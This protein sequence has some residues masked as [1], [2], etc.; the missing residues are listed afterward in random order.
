MTPQV[1][2][3][4]L[5][6]QVPEQS[7][8]GEEIL[9]TD[10]ISAVVPAESEDGTKGMNIEEKAVTNDTDLLPDYPFYFNH[11][12][13]L[14]LNENCKLPYPN[15]EREYRSLDAETFSLLHK[16]YKDIFNSSTQLMASCKSDINRYIKFKRTPYTEDNLRETEKL[17]LANIRQLRDKFHSPFDCNICLFAIAVLR[18]LARTICQCSQDCHCSKAPLR[19]HLLQMCFLALI[20]KIHELYGMALSPGKLRQKLSYKDFY[21]K[22]IDMH[23][24]NM[25]HP[26]HPS[27]RNNKPNQVV[28]KVE[29][30]KKNIIKIVCREKADIYGDKE[31]AGVYILNDKN[32]TPIRSGRSPSRSSIDRLGRRERSH[33]GTTPRSRLTSQPRNR[34]LQR[35][36][37]NPP[38]KEMNNLLTYCENRFDQRRSTSKEKGSPT[39]PSEEKT[40]VSSDKVSKVE[41]ESEKIVVTKGVKKINDD[42]NLEQM[43]RPISFQELL[44]D[45]NSGLAERQSNINSHV[46]QPSNE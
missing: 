40:L 20:T 4:Q 13:G 5:S 43:T 46:Q 29:E 19:E 9:T 22:V 37:S 7:E 39:V 44:S 17:V 8:K 32:K 41:K 15:N 24:K 27:Q 45:I 6:D 30:V 42:S 12:S 34:S 35:E 3:I 36:R 38:S 28:A 10:N 21:E 18:N 26:E 16:I 2:T 23:K 31:K 25:F 33:S 11:K 1:P 14:T